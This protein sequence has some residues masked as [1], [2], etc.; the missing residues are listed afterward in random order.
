MKKQDGYELT[1]SQSLKKI[2][3]RFTSVSSKRTIKKIIEFKRFKSNRWNLGFG[4][5][6]G[7]DW[8]DDVISDNDD[9]RKVLQT[10]ANAVHTFFELYPNDEVVIVPLERQ[11]KLLYNRIFQQRWHEIDPFFI[12]KAIVLEEANPRFESYIPKKIY[13][14]FILKLKK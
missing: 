13:D 10:V 9:L 7:K 3:F 14:Y 6:K 12:V 1:K 2:K 4:D 5:V 11:R 8:T